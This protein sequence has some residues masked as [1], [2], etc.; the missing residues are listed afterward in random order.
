MSKLVMLQPGRFAVGPDENFGLAGLDSGG[1]CI[2]SRVLEK[3]AIC[4][5]R[6]GMSSFPVHLDGQ[7]HEILARV[8]H[9]CSDV[10]LSD[11]HSGW[12]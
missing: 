4:G 2:K 12:L 3:G 8:S 9:R 10:S 1:V 5:F 7:K 6:S 11:V